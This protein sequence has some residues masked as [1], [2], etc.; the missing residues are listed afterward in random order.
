MTAR[1]RQLRYKKRAIVLFFNRKQIA[2]APKYH[3]ET[4]G[5]TGSFVDQKVLRNNEYIVHRLN[6]NKA[7][8]LH[9]TRL[10]KFVP[11]VPLEDKYKE[12]K[13]QPDASI[14]ILQDD[15]YTISWEADLEYELFEPRRNNWPDAAMRR[16]QDATNGEVDYYVTEDESSSTNNDECSSSEK[17]ENDVIENEIRPRPA[18][19]RDASSPLSETPRGTENEN[20]VTND[21]ESTEIASNGGP[22]YRKMKEMRKIL[23]L[24]EGN[25]IFDLTPPPTLLMNTDTSQICKIAS[26]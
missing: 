2:K 12:E 1:P 14:I 23:A 25:I 10:K 22:E 17:N 26:R 9:R 13:L 19:S 21:L 3:L 24:E 18:I 5:G 11:N 8:I 16:L 7:Q 15:L 6:T 20:D 4:S